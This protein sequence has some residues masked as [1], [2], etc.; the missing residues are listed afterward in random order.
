VTKPEVPLREHVI[1]LVGPTVLFTLLAS[2]VLAGCSGSDSSKVAAVGG[3]GHA[4]LAVG[5]VPGAPA[6]APPGSDSG[7]SGS[8]AC[9]AQTREGKRVPLDMYFLVD[10]SGS[11]ADDVYGGTKWDLV[12]GALIDFLQAPR[13]ADLG[14]GIG[15]FPDTQASA[16]GE[17]F[18]PSA[19]CVCVDYLNACFSTEE[20]SCSPASYAQPAVPLASSANSDAVVADLESHWVD[21]STPTRPA[22]EGAL[23]YLNGWASQHPERKPV[24][25]LTTDGEPTECDA[26]T[27]E[28]VAAVAASALAGPHSI[29][30]FVIGVGYSPESL[31]L[32]AKAGGTERAFLVDINSN[33]A[34]DFA[35][36]LDKI[37]G[38]AS[39]CDFTIPTEGAAGRKIDPHQVN[40]RYTRAQGGG[41]TL[42]PQVF[43]NDPKNCGTSDGWYYDNPTAPS[44][45]RLCESTCQTLSAGS[46]AIEFGCETIVQQP[47]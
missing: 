28:D 11:M 35:D 20:A 10:S 7:S 8:T 17:C 5:D 19:T 41:P 43:Q 33:V 27:P 25:V 42:V 4:N 18:T 15:Y 45:I 24:L 40:V 31:D 22:L 30:T 16:S 32:V 14:S 9:S 26:N 13:N 46:I 44:Q 37:R 29:K 34:M 39:S 6:I 1:G 36:A 38:A 21:G 12:S 47:R 2:A 23:Q 3:G